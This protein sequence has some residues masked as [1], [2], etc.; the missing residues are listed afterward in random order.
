MALPRISGPARTL[1]HGGQ[2]PCWALRKFG[3]QLQRLQP[4]VA[5]HAAAHAACVETAVHAT[6]EPKHRVSRRMCHDVLLRRQLLPPRPFPAATEALS[7]SVPL[8]W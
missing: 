2:A 8:R 6:N 7:A 1:P 3:L 4:A 5:P